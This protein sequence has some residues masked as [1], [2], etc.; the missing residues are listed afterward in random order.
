MSLNHRKILPGSVAPEFVAR[1]HSVAGHVDPGLP[2]YGGGPPDV[3]PFRYPHLQVRN[4]EIES[5]KEKGRYLLQGISFEVRGGELLSVMTTQTAEGSLLLSALAGEDVSTR[6]KVTGEF[7]LNGNLIDRKQ[8]KQR[9]AFVK[10]DCNWDLDL[11]VKQT[12]YFRYRL[13]RVKH[14]FAK[15]PLD[16]KVII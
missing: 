15:L 11:T 10:C 5:K 1:P 9:S 13:R 2:Y 12:L 6:G 14:R 16:D 8:L 4:L 3:G 7:I